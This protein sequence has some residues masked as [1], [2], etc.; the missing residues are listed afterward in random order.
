V[1]YGRVDALEHGQHH[2]LQ[3]EA[4]PWTA[5]ACSPHT[6]FHHVTL[7]TDEGDPTVVHRHEGSDQVVDRRAE[8]CLIRDVTVHDGRLMVA[9]IPAI[10]SIDIVTLEKNPLDFFWEFACPWGNFGC[11]FF[12]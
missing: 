12:F 10:A 9:T 3:C 8:G 4:L 11:I 6:H 1:S 5:S 2:A 7:A